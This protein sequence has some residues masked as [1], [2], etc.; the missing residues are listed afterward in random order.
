MLKKRSACMCTIFDCTATTFERYIIYYA[1]KDSSFDKLIVLQKEYLTMRRWEFPCTQR[2]TDNDCYLFVIELSKLGKVYLLISVAHHH[3]YSLII[4]KGFY[5]SRPGST[6]DFTHMQLIFMNDSFI[7]CV[8][9]ILKYWRNV[10][11]TE[12]TE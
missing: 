9:S 11:I 10:L 7:K 1:S 4:T 12:E 5:S 8:S 2:H 6:L 3:K